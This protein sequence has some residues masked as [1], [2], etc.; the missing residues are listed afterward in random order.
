MRLL[1]YF[2]N[3][4][5]DGYITIGTAL[6]N[7]INIVNITDFTDIML[8]Y[9]YL[10]A[11]YKTQTGRITDANMLSDIFSI[12]ESDQYNTDYENWKQ[13]YVTTKDPDYKTLKNKILLLELNNKL[14]PE[15][16]IGYYNETKDL[17]YIWKNPGYEDCMQYSP[18]NNC[19][20]KL[21]YDA[22]VILPKQF[23]QA[24]GSKRIKNIA[25][26]EDV[27]QKLHDEKRFIY[28]VNIKKDNDKYLVILHSGNVILSNIDSYA[29]IGDRFTI[30]KPA[31]LKHSVY[32]MNK[33]LDNHDIQCFAK[34]YI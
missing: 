13:S 15:F 29:D 34:L 30:V 9:A 1:Q 31:K 17:F 18:Y 21:P 4:Q 25:I 26:L 16:A 22:Y 7:I 24:I 32:H 19:K 23:K 14:T 27:I 12:L 2:K 20:H 5:S 8:E 6:H 33:A 3:R 28:D 11:N 10:K